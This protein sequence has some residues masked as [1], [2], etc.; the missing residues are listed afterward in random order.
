MIRQGTRKHT[1][2]LLF[3]IL[4][5]ILAACGTG[6]TTTSAP[7]TTSAA[8]AAATPAV[9]TPY[10]VKHIMGETT[11]KGNPQ[12]V[13][14]LVNDAVEASLALGIKPVG[15][16]KAWG[17]QPYYDH[18]KD[19]LEGVPIVGDENQPNLEAIAALKP[20]LIIGN[21]LRQ[22]KIYQQLSSIAPTV[23]SE[24]T[25]SDSLINFKI[26]AGAL[27]KNEE[28][29]KQLAAFE[30]KVKDLQQKLGDKTNTKVSLVRFYLEDK[31]RVY[32]QDTFAGGILKKIG[33][34]RPAAQDKP[35][36]AEIIGKERI[37]EL[38]GDI[39]FYFTLED[40]KG[41]TA[42]TEKAWQE[43]TLWKNLDVVKKGKA[44]KVN[45]GIWNSSGGIISANLMVD[46]LSKHLLK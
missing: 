23:F 7:P 25:N 45:D 35:T 42:K 17:V 14:I 21:K 36:F 13:V 27:N 28:G 12:R 20:D 1:M 44:I 18:L 39:L 40:D 32:Y 9:S 46:E 16:V 31:V 38:D 10:T 41:M 3:I 2:G 19:K 15:M 29:E 8:G 33:L 24:R 43:E 34:K 11:V 26:Y 4:S 22:E 30:T 5:L 37:P 6:T